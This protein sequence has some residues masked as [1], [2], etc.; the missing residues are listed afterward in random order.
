M[1]YTGVAIAFGCSVLIGFSRTYYLK[2][3]F[4]APSLSFQTAL[5]AAGRTD[6]HRRAGA[7]GGV[8]AVA[9]VFLG[10]AMAFHSVRVGYA[11]GRPNMDLLL[12]NS[13]I[14]LI[15]FSTF[16]AAGLFLRRNKE[17]HKRLMLLA[18]VSLIIP[19]VARLPIPSTM[20]GWVILAFSLTGVVYDGIVLRRVYVTS[21]VG[22]LLINVGTPLR[23]AIA[24]T[25]AWQAFVEWAAR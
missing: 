7:P 17:I 3:W 12:V 15:L 25:R 16:L 20:I 19:S 21:V 13:I 10:A 18:M 23:F 6:L 24:G 5:V 22:A 9:V 1:F 11:S 4:G 8:L 14:D 2:P